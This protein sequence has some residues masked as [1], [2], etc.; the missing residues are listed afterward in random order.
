AGL[1]IARHQVVRV[2]LAEVQ[3]DDEIRRALE[4][5]PGVQRLAAVHRTHHALAVPRIAE[6]LERGLH[7]EDRLVALRSR[8]D[9]PRL[10]AFE[11]EVHR[12]EVVE[13]VAERRGAAPVDRAEARLRLEP[14]GEHGVA[15]AED[16]LPELRR[17]ARE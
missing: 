10:A 15:E 6:G 4:E 8:D 17:E 9:A 1:R 13:L 3:L 16:A 14:R 2:A 11:V 5:G 7:P 12:G